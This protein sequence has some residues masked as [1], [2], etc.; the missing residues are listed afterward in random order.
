M[1]DNTMA[2]P[3]KTFIRSSQVTNHGSVRMR[4]KQSNSPPKSHESCLW[5]NL[6]ETNGGMFLRTREDDSLF[7]TAMRCLTH[8]L[9]SATGQNVELMGHPP[10]SPNLA[11]NDFSLLPHIRKK[12]R[13]QRFSSLEDTVGVFWRCL[14][15]SGKTNTNDGRTSKHSEYDYAKKCQTFLW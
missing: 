8:R 10:Y 15:R 7:T 9:K 2:V 5:K 4:P 6:F 12:M 1:L 3:Q 11:P 14:N 13:G